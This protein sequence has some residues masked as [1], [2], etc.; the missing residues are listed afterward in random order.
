MHKI[1]CVD[2]NILTI[3]FDRINSNT[4]TIAA[5]LISTLSDPL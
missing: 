4:I 2:F 5:T 1:L 3:A